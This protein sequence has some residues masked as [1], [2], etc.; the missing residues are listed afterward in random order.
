VDAKAAAGLVDEVLNTFCSGA[1]VFATD[2]FERVFLS[3]FACGKG[4]T[5]LLPSR[6]RGGGEG[7]KIRAYRNGFKTARCFSLYEMNKASIN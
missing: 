2:I 6:E 7:E 4:K 1:Y 5:S 3:S